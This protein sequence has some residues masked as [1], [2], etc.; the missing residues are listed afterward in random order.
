MHTLQFLDTTF[1][2]GANEAGQGGAT[3]TYGV[4]AMV[5][6]F[7]ILAYM[8]RHTASGRHIYAVGDD[9]DA[10]QLSGVN[11]RAT[12]ISV[13]A[14]TGFICAIA[15]WSSGMAV[16]PRWTIAISIFTRARFWP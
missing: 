1:K 8:L 4:I 7:V 16:S 15:G 10:A 13:Y 6:I 2:V 11:V 12:I 14:L 9:P 3:F 5:L